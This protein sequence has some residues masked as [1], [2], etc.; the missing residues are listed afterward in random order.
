MVSGKLSTTVYVIITCKAYIAASNWSFP[1]S[2]AVKHFVIKTS[3]NQVSTANITFQAAKRLENMTESS[4][5]RNTIPFGKKQ[6][7][8][9]KVDPELS[10]T[11]NCQ[12]HCIS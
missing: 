9:F 10:M 3:S 12:V 1:W 7:S 11:Q 6:I 8:F 2:G 4:K 5:Y